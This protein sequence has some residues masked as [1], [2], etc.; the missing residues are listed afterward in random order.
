MS[1]KIFV[2]SIKV[3]G[4]NDGFIDFSGQVIVQHS[5]IDKGKVVTIEYTMNSWATGN[6]VIAKKSPTISNNNQE[7][8]YFE[9][10]AFKTRNIPLNLEFLA[11]FDI[12][13]STFWANSNYEYSY[14]EGY[15]KEFF[16]HDNIIENP[17]A[18]YNSI[19]EN[20]LNLGEERRKL[21]EEL[22]EDRMLRQ[23][24]EER[25]RVEQERRRLEEER[26]LLEEE[27][28]LLREEQR[29]FNENRK[30]QAPIQ[31]T[32]TKECS[33]CLK[34]LNVKNFSNITDQCGHDVYI[35]RKC[36]GEHIA[37]AVNKGCIKILCLENN[38]RKVLNESDVR[39]FVNNEIF[40]RYMLNF[41]LSEIPTFKWCLNP[42][43]GSGQDHYY[44][45][46]V[47]IMTCNTCGQKSCIVHGLQIETECEICR[48]Y[49]EELN[50][51]LQEIQLQDIQLQETDV[52]K[53]CI[54]CT[55]NVDIRAFL[56]ITDQCS[57]DYNICRE[58]VKEYIKHEIED[59]GNVKIKC[60]GDG[61]KEFL[62]QKDI[63]EFASEESFKRYERFLLNLALSEIPTFQWCLNPN[64]GSGQDHDQ[65]DNPIMI[66]NSCGNKSCVEHG[67]PINA[68]CERCIEE[69]EEVERRLQEEEERLREEERRWQEE[70]Q[71][72][73]EEEERR[74]REEERRRREEE[75]R[76]RREEERRRREEEE[77]RRREEEERRQ[78]FRRQEEEQRRL[79]ARQNAESASE[80]FVNTMKQCP[81]CKC[82]IEKNGGCNHMTCR[83]PGCGHQ[84]CWV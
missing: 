47:P 8:Y 41:A 54:I 76:R 81:K 82:R 39:K 25:R 9:I 31:T 57:H 60:P 70:E 61:C 59:N 1:D 67:L 22:E 27:R 75:E 56:N 4:E 77:R 51:Q 24:E 37:H 74:R 16:F 52:N 65:E 32:E 80:S 62:N 45:D 33:K 10:S 42:I 13:D 2:K 71:R 44:G 53:E 38:C 26:R 6:S 73:R 46:N 43:C 19:E 63:K 34:D 20:G 15:P 48:Q 69:E 58:C 14:N 12:A 35:C 84:F 30:Q 17:F 68:E 50:L 5:N 36:I 3:A 40:E 78:R 21:N 64:C 18:D 28:R 55:E 49:E 83:R 23:Q 72:R 7:L 79:A 66:C 29:L 11:R